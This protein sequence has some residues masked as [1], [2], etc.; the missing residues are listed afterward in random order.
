MR[1]RLSLPRKAR[2]TATKEFNE[3]ISK[4]KALKAEFFRLHYLENYTKKSRIGII[5]SRNIKEKA[6]KNKYKRCVKEYFRINRNKFIKNI[7][8]VIIIYRQNKEKVTQKI[9]EILKKEKIVE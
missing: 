1:K 5:V 8:V 3:I 2:I 9:E 7:D 6:I 4:G